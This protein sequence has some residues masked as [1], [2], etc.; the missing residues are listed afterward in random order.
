MIAQK[1]LWMF[2]T[3]LIHVS[4]TWER[5]R[6]EQ[7]HQEMPL[8]NIESV[9]EIVLIADEIFLNDVIQ[10]FLNTSEEE[11]DDYWEE[12]TTEGFSDSYI[13]AIADERIRREYL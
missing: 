5:I 12:N 9:D 3:I 2:N 11:R 7:P 6:L 1:D 4:R 8:D 13:E 10:E